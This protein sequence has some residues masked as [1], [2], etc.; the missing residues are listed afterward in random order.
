MLPISKWVS[1]ASELVLI[2]RKRKR[3]EVSRND[4]YGVCCDGSTLVQ[5]LSITNELQVHKVTRIR[6]RR[7]ERKLGFFFVGGGFAFTAPSYK[8]PC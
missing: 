5:V 6:R 2:G 3:K 8:T 7:R 4:N 1:W